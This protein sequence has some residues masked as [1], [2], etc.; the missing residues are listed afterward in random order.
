[1]TWKEKKNKILLMFCNLGI[2][3]TYSNSTIE[4]EVEKDGYVIPSKDTL[5]NT[6]EINIKEIEKMLKQLIN[7]GK[8]KEKT[9]QLMNHL[10][11]IKNL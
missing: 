1:M 7:N 9:N 3:A 8:Y 6:I 11:A 2:Y 5:S 4:I 10:L